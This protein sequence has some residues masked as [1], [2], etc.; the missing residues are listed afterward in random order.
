MMVDSINSVQTNNLTPPIHET[1]LRDRRENS[2]PQEEKTLKAKDSV[3]FQFNIHGNLQN[4]QRSMNEISSQIQQQLDHY[5]EW[6]GESDPE[7]Q[8][9]FS[10]P[11]NAS[12]QQIVDF[13]N[14]ENTSQRILDFGLGFFDVYLQNHNTSINEDSIDEFYHLLNDAFNAGFDEAE[15][16]LGSFDE[17]GEIGESIK[18]TYNSV[19]EGLE[20]FRLEHFNELGLMPESTE[21]P[22]EDFVESKIEDL[23]FNL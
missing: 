22:V 1:A 20:E 10:L 6:I 8:S 4:L 18:Q 17:M 23:G 14:P 13:Y 5:F 9:Q 7:I 21:N 3:D 15:E 19:M 12:A 2:L 11:E 16:I